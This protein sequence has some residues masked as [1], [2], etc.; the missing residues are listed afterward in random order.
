ML[1][2][3]ILCIKRM[4]EDNDAPTLWFLLECP[5]GL[6]PGEEAWHVL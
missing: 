4:S 6:P 2:L 5:P 1:E 3:P